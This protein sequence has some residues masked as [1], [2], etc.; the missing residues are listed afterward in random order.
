MPVVINELEVVPEA[1]PPA[2]ANGS[3][4]SQSDSGKGE[5]KPDLED[6]LRQTHERRERVRAH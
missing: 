5:E 2:P 6:Q 3:P 4:G 1:A